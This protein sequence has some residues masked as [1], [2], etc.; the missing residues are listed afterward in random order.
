MFSAVSLNE[1]LHSFA[2][3]FF[4]KTNFKRSCQDRH[5]KETLTKKFAHV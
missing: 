1:A 4:M 2:F 5:K 3:Y